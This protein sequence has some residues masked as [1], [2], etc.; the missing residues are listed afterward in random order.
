MLISK[1][2]FQDTVSED[3]FIFQISIYYLFIVHFTETW[4]YE[5]IKMKYSIFYF[6]IIEYW[7]L[8]VCAI[9]WR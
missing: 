3:Q 5:H 6:V 4:S 2:Y 8:L 1:F 7:K 9:C